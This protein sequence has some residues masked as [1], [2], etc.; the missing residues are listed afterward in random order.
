MRKIERALLA[1]SDK[2]GI[3]HFAQT[4]V[5]HDVEILSTGGTAQKLRDA[6]IPVREVADVTEFPE[7]L[8][9]RVKTLH[10]RIHG[11][12]LARRH[13]ESDLET[14]AEHG[15]P[16]IDLVVINLYPFEQRTAEGVSF[17]QAIEEID[18]GGPA[19]IRAA[20][21]NHAHVGVIVDPSRYDAVASELNANDGQL[22]PDTRRQLA[23]DAFRRTAAYDAAISNWLGQQAEGRFPERWTEQW[24][25]MGELRYGEN[26]HQNAAWYSRSD[27]G[28][29]S[30]PA[31]K[32]L[33]GKKAVSY[34]NLLD[35]AAAID[36]ARSLDGA[37]AV[38]VKHCL[39]CGAAERD[40]IHDAFEAALAGDPLSAFGG[41]LALTQPL[42]RELATRISSPDLFFE[43]IHAPEFLD[44]A[45]EAI[46]SGAKWGKSCRLLCGGTIDGASGRPTEVRSIPGGVLLQDCD[47]FQA[48]RDQ[49]EVVSSRPP[50]DEE[51][52]DLLFAWR[53]I[54]SVRSN[55]I[56]LAK[57]RSVV[58][59]G[60]GQ[61]SRVD[62][63][64]IACR[65]AGDRSRG[66]VLA[67]DAF[68]PFSDGVQAAA[69]AGVTAV[70]QPGGSRRD[71]EVVEAA[72]AANIAVVITGERHFKH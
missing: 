11:G 71:G 36:C 60:A 20:A 9:G 48:Q 70:I 28:S 41:I 2:S 32:L 26:P 18:I 17:D 43:V 66:S 33:E 44:G 67:S 52:A 47:H 31:A 24:T 21:K 51:W 35:V 39:P 50:T 25:R 5:D 63:V 55:G 72:N 13:L 59:A 56:L 37:G 6:G 7:M 10:P 29:F 23:L 15:I 64:A 58:G 16:M 38:V 65:K 46:R 40:T 54:P 53:V 45:E 62:S 30:L 34:N 19:M 22:G 57:E 27:G 12:I 3:T 8:G 42:D 68:F 49:F 4:L 14:A 69:E 61:P 1:V